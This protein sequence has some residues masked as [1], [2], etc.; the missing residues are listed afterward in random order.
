MDTNSDKMRDALD[1]VAAKLI[2][3]PLHAAAVKSLNHADRVFVSVYGAHRVIQTS[4]VEK[5]IDKGFSGDPDLAFLSA[6]LADIGLPELADTLDK[7]RALTSPP[8]NCL[9]PQSFANAVKRHKSEFDRTNRMFWLSVT[10]ID[11]CLWLHV[12][13]Q[14]LRS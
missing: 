6:A 4:G 9:N 2:P 1:V 8:W 14:G 3:K 13:N 11:Y 5:L 10:K 7:L 12:T